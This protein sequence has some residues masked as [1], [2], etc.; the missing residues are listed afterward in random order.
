MRQKRNGQK[1]EWTTWNEKVFNLT[2]KKSDANE[3]HDEIAL[4][5]TDGK[6]LTFLIKWIGKEGCGE[7]VT[8]HKPSLEFSW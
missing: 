8:S 1:Y 6:D 7:N 3:N 4:S 5:K 2:Q